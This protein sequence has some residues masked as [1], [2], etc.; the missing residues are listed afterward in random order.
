M[1]I[2]AA[3][4][5]GSA[6]PGA[7]LLASASQPVRSSSTRQPNWLRLPTTH[8]CHAGTVSRRAIPTQC[9]R[10]RRRRSAPSTGCTASMTATTSGSFW[11]FKRGFDG[12]QGPTRRTVAWNTIV[13]SCKAKNIISLSLLSLKITHEAQP[14]RKERRTKE[15]IKKEQEQ[16]IR[17]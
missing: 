2:P 7:V 8:V 4:A 17:N 6:S 3:T 15:R 14:P 16:D 11:T 13:E 5:A 9:I 12:E 10:R 1:F